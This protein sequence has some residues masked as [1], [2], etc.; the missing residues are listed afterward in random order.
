M[1]L[2]EIK[3]LKKSYFSPTGSVEVLKGINI[4]IEK[5]EFVSIMG[6]SGS[7]KS[8][9]MNILGCLD[10]FDSGTYFIN[11]QNPAKLEDSALADL[12]CRTIGFVFQ[13]FNLMPK[14]NLLNNV[15]LPMIYAQ[16]AKAYREKRALE[17]LTRVGLEDFAFRLPTNIS[18]GQQQRVAIARALSNNPSLILADEP[19]GNLDTKTSHQVMDLLSELNQ[20]GTTIVIVTHEY[21]VARYAKRM[22][23]LIDGDVV[24]DGSFLKDPS[25]Q[26]GV[27]KSHV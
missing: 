15:V 8:T 14:M 3:N 24:Y 26:Q 20:E 22:I 6:P 21:D 19:T 13:G 25:L 1:S 17:L 7:G 11:Q 2:I 18:G 27:E 16:A 12:R 4:K 5:G 23:R 9:L 10:R